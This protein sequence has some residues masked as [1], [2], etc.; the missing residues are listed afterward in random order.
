MSDQV[1]FDTLPTADG[2][3]IGRVT[4]DAPRS[5]NALSLGM[6]DALQERLDAW[7]RLLLER[8]GVLCRDLLARESLAPPWF[9]LVPR[10]RRLEALSFATVLLFATAVTNAADAC[11]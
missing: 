11:S 5:L 10:L 4:L 3:R 1:R 7:A 9:Q 6:I 2:H 8:Y